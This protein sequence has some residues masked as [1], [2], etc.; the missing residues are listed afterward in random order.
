MKIPTKDDCIKLLS[1]NENYKGILN[2]A[3]DEAEKKM[4]TSF[5]HRMI[6]SL[7]NAMVPIIVDYNKNPDE[8][9]KKLSEEFDTAVFTQDTNKK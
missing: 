4:I 7:T 8:F 1:E 6:E 5:T 9:K 3:R 2:L